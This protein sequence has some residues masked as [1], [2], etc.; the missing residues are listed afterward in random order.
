MHTINQDH[1]TTKVINR[2]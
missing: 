1:A 2:R